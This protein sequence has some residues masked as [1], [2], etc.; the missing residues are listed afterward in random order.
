M[1]TQPSGQGSL[2][3]HLRLTDLLGRAHNC[4]GTAVGYRDDASLSRRVHGDDKTSQS[5]RARPAH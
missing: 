2:P 4:A 3:W 1:H 5:V